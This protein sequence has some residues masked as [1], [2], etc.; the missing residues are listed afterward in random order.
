MRALALRIQKRVDTVFPLNGVR[1]TE[2]LRPR[3]ALL[4]QLSKNGS[5]RMASG[6]RAEESKVAD[7][8]SVVIWHMVR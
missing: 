5:K 6:A 7:G 8:V 2:V 1:P 4:S 3:T